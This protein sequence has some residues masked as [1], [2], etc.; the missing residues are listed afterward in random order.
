MGMKFWSVQVE[1]AAPRQLANCA[2]CRIGE[3]PPTKA[4]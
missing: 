3:V 1:A 2:A 4:V